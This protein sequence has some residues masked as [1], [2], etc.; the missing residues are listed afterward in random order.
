M[1]TPVE[2]R[3]KGYHIL[4][5]HLGQT[6]VIRFLQQMGWGQGNYTEERCEILESVTR[7][8]FLQD[9]RKIRSL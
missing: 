5:S 2:L 7:E 4:V 6:D 9:L 1:M 8:E 3:E